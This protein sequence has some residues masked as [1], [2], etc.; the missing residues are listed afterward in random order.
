MPDSSL[1]ISPCGQLPVHTHTH[2]H[3]LQHRQ[4]QKYDFIVSE[5]AVVVNEPGPW[6][7]GRERH[8][9]HEIEGYPHRTPLPSPLWW[10][11]VV[12]VTLI[13]EV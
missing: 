1:L 4:Q 11:G 12:V 5:H 7:R 3:T 13:G 2:T 10:T 6:K 9:R 8:K